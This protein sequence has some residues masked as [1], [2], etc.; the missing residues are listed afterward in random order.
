MSVRYGY[1]I[2]ARFLT[3]FANGNLGRV[4]CRWLRLQQFGGA[5]QR[6]KQMPSSKLN[7]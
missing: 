7:V 5:F 2:A 4:G 6:L 1:Q 3:V